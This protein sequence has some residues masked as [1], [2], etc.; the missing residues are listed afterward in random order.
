[1]IAPSSQPTGVVPLPTEAQE[2]LQKSRLIQSIPL[3]ALMG[4]GGVI[5]GYGSG[6]VLLRCA[7]ESSNCELGPDNSE[8]AL[9]ALGL[10]I[11]ASTG[12][13]LGGRRAKSEGDRWLTFAA[14]A[15]GALPMIIGSASDNDAL[16]LGSTGL[17]ITAAVVTDHYEPIRKVYR[18]LDCSDD[19]YCYDRGC[20][21]QGEGRSY[22]L[23]SG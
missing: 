6:L 5:L 21:R 13:H 3:S 20:Y 12:A 2:P 8:Y 9:A 10:A 17:S 1:M 16:I 23:G 15:A 11:G 7:D 4:V 18:V 19:S 22:D 14:A